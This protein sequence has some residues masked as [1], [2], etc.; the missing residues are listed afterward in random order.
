MHR[1]PD[2]AAS[3]RSTTNHRSGTVPEYPATREMRINP[4]SRPG[5]LPSLDGLRAVSITL[6]VVY[7]LWGT[8][9]DRYL[10]SLGNL[11]VRVFFVI[12]GFLITGILLN[13]LESTNSISLKQFY[14]RRALRIFPAFYVYCIAA[15]VIAAAG[16]IIVEPR[17]LL[18]AATYTI[19]IFPGAEQSVYVKHIW[20]LCVEEQFY[21][22]WPA[23]LCIAGKRRGLTIACIWLFAAPTIRILYW[24]YFPGLHDVIDRRFETVA[25]ALATGC[26][27]AG[28]QSWL[29][30]AESYNRFLCSRYF[31]LVPVFVY[32]DANFVGLHPRVYLA[33][34][35]TLLNVA[36]A[37]CI[38]RWVRYPNGIAGRFLNISP[39]RTVGVMSY[40]LY[41]WQQP[42]VSPESVAF[43]KFP[44]NIVL[45]CVFS[46]GSFFLIEKPFQRLKSKIGRG[47]DANRTSRAKLES[48]SS[49]VPS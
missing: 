36:I 22:I 5:R 23:L 33:M 49:R 27:L 3:V 18:E 25:D 39:V 13:E 17:D 8:R 44:I 15:G 45:A 24:L 42:F 20:S 38:D 31:A 37:L 4:L 43:T 19:N 21:L 46:A 26:L 6:V 35:Q 11:G 16:L 34:G 10:G 14:A 1:A 7:H 30:N 48:K 32:L 29:S 12:S 41:L 47:S 40:S 28:I 2:G 9:F